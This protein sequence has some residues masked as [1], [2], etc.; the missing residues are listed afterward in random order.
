[1]RLR[2]LRNIGSPL[3][4]QAILLYTGTGTGVYEKCLM[5]FAAQH[6]QSV[7]YAWVGMVALLVVGAA[8]WRKRKRHVLLQLD[9]VD[10]QEALAAVEAD[11]G[12]ATELPVV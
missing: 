9:N 8:A 11:Q 6:S 4:L 10:L 7:A 2:S 3:Y 12:H 5:E 1:M